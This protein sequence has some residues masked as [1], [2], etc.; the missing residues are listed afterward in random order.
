MADDLGDD[1]WDDKP[2]DGEDESRSERQTEQVESK[3]IFNQ[4]MHDYE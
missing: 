3:L 1:W 2:A 4:C